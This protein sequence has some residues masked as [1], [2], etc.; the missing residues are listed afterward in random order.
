ME[1]KRF[2]ALLTDEALT[3]EMEEIRVLKVFSETELT[4]IKEKKRD[5]R[6]KLRG[7]TRTSK[8]LKEC[9]NYEK[10]IVA[11][12]TDRLKHEKKSSIT[13]ALVEN[14]RYIYD[15]GIKIF[16]NDATL[17]MECFDFCRKVKYFHG[18]Q[19][20]VDMMYKLHQNND[21]VWYLIVR[22]Y[23][24]DI[25]NVHKGYRLLNEGLNLHK[26][27][28]ILL[29]EKFELEI[30]LA[31]GRNFKKTE[32]Q[33][34]DLMEKEN[35]CLEKLKKH[36]EDI[37]GLVHASDLYVDI[38]QAIEKYDFTQPI[39]KS[40]VTY[41][42]QNYSSEAI[43]WDIV[44]KREAKGFFDLLDMELKPNRT[45]QEAMFDQCIRRYQDGLNL[46][47]GTEKRKLW[48]IY[49][50]YLVDQEKDIPAVTKMKMTML[51]KGLDEASA[52]GYK[53]PDHYLT[54][55]AF[56]EH[57]N[58][59]EALMHGGGTVMFP[60]NPDVW[61]AY[62]KRAMKTQ[63]ALLMRDVF[64]R[65]LMKLKD[66]SYPLWLQMIRYEMLMG[67]EDQ[68][69]S[70]YKVGCKSLGEVSVKLRPRFLDY[71]LL[72][73]GITVARAS[74]L[75]MMNFLPPSKQLHSKMAEL[76]LSQININ[77]A[78]LEQVYKNAI[79]QFGKTDVDVWLDYISFYYKIKRSADLKKSTDKVC[80]EAKQQLSEELIS[81]FSIKLIEFLKEMEIVKY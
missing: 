36:F 68:V 74:Y 6:L 63:D 57:G 75:D 5:L 77:M 17:L 53:F 23:A 34:I 43:V 4:D 61:C 62:L 24:Y 18:C 58:D 64:H 56:Q 72:T 71:L 12:I 76:E 26:S 81:Q 11:E 44:A 40:I 35:V 13:N 47:Q 10:R 70:L 65:G 28:K 54:W 30:I 46:V 67:H 1:R 41:L 16:S 32:P 39:Q 50:D 21:K 20:A 73:K 25:G 49:L 33:A 8:D 31:V 3:N 52:Q 14:I 38:V 78:Q 66:K 51:R 27:S 37:K 48:R 80:A 22:F 7:P 59:M 55:L 2:E 9:I 29:K 60:K 42:Y 15:V 19:A 45:S 69:I 79:Q